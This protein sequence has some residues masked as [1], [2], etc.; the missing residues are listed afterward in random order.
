MSQSTERPN[1]RQL[2]VQA[3]E[4]VRA[5]HAADPAAIS[6][7]TP[8]FQPASE[9][10][11]ANAQLVI[12]RENGFESWPRLRREL[13][14]SPPQPKSASGLLFE[15]LESGDDDGAAAIVRQSPDLAGVWRLGEYG[16]TTPLHMAA[17]MGRAAA[18]RALVEVGA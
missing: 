6:R 7:V 1:L 18:V 15:A 5:V 4:L 9:F 13:D 16:W 17:T 2:R 11:L 10:T 3:K 8:Y 12:A 14:P